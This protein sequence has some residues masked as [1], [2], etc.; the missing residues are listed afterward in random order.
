MKANEEL[1]RIAAILA[2][3]FVK[4]VDYEFDDETKAT[5]L[6]ERGIEKVEEA[7][8]VDNLYDLEHQ[9]LYHYVIQAVRAHVMFEKMSITS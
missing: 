9:T 3:R 1:H 8:G 7:F 5:T 6:T 2:K 4:D